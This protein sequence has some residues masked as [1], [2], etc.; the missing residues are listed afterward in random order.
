MYTYYAL[1]IY[2]WKPVYRLAIFITTIQLAQMIGGIFVILY[3]AYM[4]VIDG[5]YCNH[6]PVNW[7]LGIA[8]YASYFTLFSILFYQ[9]YLQ[10]KSEHGVKVNTPCF[11]EPKKISSSGDFRVTEAGETEPS[12]KPKKKQQ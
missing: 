12:P 11:A 4:Q 3:A 5:S 1:A 8:M 6:H 7:K 10:P 9:K 2:G